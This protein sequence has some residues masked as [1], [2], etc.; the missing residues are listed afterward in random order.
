MARELI[1]KIDHDWLTETEKCWRKRWHW[2][3]VYFGPTTFE[4]HLGPFS[5][6]ITI[7]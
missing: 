4:F 6:E 3:E 5:M 7:D 1:F 2:I